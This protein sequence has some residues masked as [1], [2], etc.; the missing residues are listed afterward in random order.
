[1][2][3]KDYFPDHKPTS[4]LLF[5]S[6]TA[7]FQ[8]CPAFYFWHQ[9]AHLEG[10][11]RPSYFKFGSDFHVMALKYGLLHGVEAGEHWLVTQPDIAEPDK[12]L[13]LNMYDVFMRVWLSKPRRVI[14]VEESVL[15]PI[16][17]FT[18]FDTW[19]VKPDAVYEEEDGSKWCMD[20]KTTSGYGAATAKY[21]HQSLQTKTFFHVQHELDQTLAGTKIFVAT[22]TKDPRVEVEEIVLNS[23][24][25][26]QA[27]THMQEAATAIDRAVTDYTFPRNCQSCVNFQGKECPY[28]PLCMD[29]RVGHGNAHQEDL[30]ANWFKTADPDEHLEL[31]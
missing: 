19:V 13:M 28:I 3:P 16:D 22:K 17:G 11:T 10:P 29:H 21:Y 7:D 20:L 23:L 24:D 6:K 1:M 14:S 5:N 31:E 18:H 2:N 15:F 9:H 8:S 30:L 27:K 12:M 4:R 25:H 26:H